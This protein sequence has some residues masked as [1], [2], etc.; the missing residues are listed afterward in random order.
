MK[1][2]FLL[3]ASVI[4]AAGIC[5]TFGG[6]PA[7]ARGSN[8]AA[9][10]TPIPAVTPTLV[11]KP[12]PDDEVIKI[13]T[14]LVNLTVRVVDRNN[15]VI[16]N[17]PEKD[18][19]IF[20]DGVLQKIGFFSTSEVP[21]N[22]AIVVDNS[23]SMRSQI[24]KVIEAGK[25]MVN[26]NRPA[27]ATEIVRFVS[28]DK[29][30]VK[31][32]FTSN[33]DDLKYALDNMNIEGGQTAIIDAVYLA[34]QSIDE[35]KKTQKSDDHRRKALILVSDGED[36]SSFYNMEQLFELL[37]ESEVQIYV[38]G[39]TDELGKTGNFIG[40]SPQ[41]KARAFLDRMA[42]ETGGKAYY[43]TS[44]NDLPRLATEISNELRT[45]YSIGY[46]PSNDKHD[47]TYRSIRVSVD[48]CPDKQRRIAITRAGRTADK[49]IVPPNAQKSPTPVKNP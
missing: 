24:E 42:T 38:I 41:G 33:K 13:D 34:V 1:K 23:G 4:F 31:Q 14:D 32:D 30:E 9:T 2:I 22:Y 43:P 27:D 48:D 8:A 5:V 40:K 15:H 18:F 25:I 3:L 44:L 20:E 7:S 6:S 28:S 35:Y 17:I 39:F 36:R 26:T 49:D 12:T 29:I 10:P 37:K 21:T 47:G 19:K 16:N 11:P 45:Q 46:E